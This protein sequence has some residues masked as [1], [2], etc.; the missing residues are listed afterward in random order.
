MKNFLQSGDKFFSQ[1]NL[2]NAIKKLG[3]SFGDT[4]CIHSEIFSLG[5]PLVP[6]DEFLSI[7]TQS[8]LD[9]VGYEGTV[10]MPTFTYSFCRGEVYDIKNSKSTMGVLSEFF[11]KQSGVVRTSDPIFSF[12]VWGKNRSGFLKDHNDCFGK[13]CVYETL[14]KNKGKLISF[15]SGKF[16]YTFAH[17]A[18]QVAKVSYRYFKEFDGTFIDQDGT[19]HI[20]KVKYFVRYLDKNSILDGNKQTELL[21]N[22]N[23]FKTADFGLVCVD[24]RRY[25]D[26]LLR[27]F[28]KDENYLLV[29]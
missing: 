11:R 18:E 2:T 28:K 9:S 19:S 23:N 21:K 24:A 15:G 10:L 17:Y 27:L 4:I 13:D 16:W 26:E 20:K 6:R 1:D 29:K 7:I 12:A 25:F 14:L 22:S 8:F 5:R 3:V